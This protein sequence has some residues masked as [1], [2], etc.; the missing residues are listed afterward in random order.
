MPDARDWRMLMA[1]YLTGLR[2]MVMARRTVLLV[3][4]AAAPAALTLLVVAVA[5]LRAGISPPP[6]A[7]LLRAQSG[8]FL[9]ILMPLAAI[10]YGGAVI[11]DEVEAGTFVYIWARPV[12]RWA[13]VLGRSLAAATATALVA[14]T[15]VLLMGA[16][17]MTA[18]MRVRLFLQLPQALGAV[19]L[20]ALAYAALFAAFGSWFR[21]SMV[22]G[23]LWALIWE[24]IVAYV[25]G[26]VRYMTISHYA[27]SLFPYVRENT[28]IF[29]QGFEP[30]PAWLSAFVLLAGAAA[31]LAAHTLWLRLFELRLTGDEG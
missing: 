22:A 23:L 11:A 8:F 18:G 1:L 5:W 27:R 12:P 20:A 31:V 17:S 2:Q 14:C 24:N 13:L 29:A 7:D 21:R 26:G 10:L 3:L 16:A 4:L 28:G 15:G 25:P 19:C 9:R 30:S 6:P